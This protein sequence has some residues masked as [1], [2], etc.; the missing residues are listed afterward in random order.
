MHL[1]F[2]IL[3][4]WAAIAGLVLSSIIGPNLLGDSRIPTWR[5]TLYGFVIGPTIWAVALA[6]VLLMTIVHLSA[7][8]K[9]RRAAKASGSS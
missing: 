3:L 8:D 2:H 4:Y 6:A 7:L 1:I 5:R 9:R